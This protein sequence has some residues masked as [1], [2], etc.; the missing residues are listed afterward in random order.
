MWAI[1]NCH[2]K[3]AR[4]SGSTDEEFAKEMEAQIPGIVHYLYQQAE[5]RGGKEQ[6]RPFQPNEAVDCHLEHRLF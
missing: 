2:V 3:A 4:L 5:L 6:H 1:C